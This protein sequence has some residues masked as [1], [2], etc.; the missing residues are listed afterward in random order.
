MCVL[1]HSS[2]AAAQRPRSICPVTPV[3][4][5]ARQ[6]APFFPLSILLTPRHCSASLQ[7]RPPSA[8]HTGLISLECNGLIKETPCTSQP[9]TR[10]SATLN[11][12]HGSRD[13]N[14]AITLT[15]GVLP[16]QTAPSAI[17]TIISETVA[18]RRTDTGSDTSYCCR[19]FSLQR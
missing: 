15:D 11:P 9:N 19:P 18:S 14:F 2:N 1:D 8:A 5:T 3:L 10:G 16:L 13:H 7:P 12:P 6:T 4:S 17:P